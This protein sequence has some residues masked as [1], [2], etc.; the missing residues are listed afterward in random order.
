MQSLKKDSD[1]LG[2]G[3]GKTIRIS[4]L[5][6]IKSRVAQRYSTRRREDF[7]S[8]MI[9]FSYCLAYASVRLL[10]SST[11]ELDEAE[12][13]LN[14]A[15]F[16]L[17]Y[18]DQPPLYS[19]IIKFLSLIF[20][21]NLGTIILVKYALIFSFFFFFYLIARSFWMPKESLI[22]T[23]SLLLFPTYGYEFHRDLSH[24]ILMTMTAVA[25]CLFYV[26]LLQKE[27]K[28]DYFLF[29]LSVGLGFLSKVNFIF[30]LLPLLAASM[31]VREGRRAL[32]DKK[33]F[34]SILPCFLVLLPHIFWLASENFPSFRHAVTES[35][36]GYLKE[37]SVKQIL[38]VIT[39]VFGG[40]LVF[41]FSFILF[42]RH[43]LDFSHVRPPEITLLQR[44]AL[45]GLISPVFLIFFLHSAYFSGR[46]LAP[47]F[48]ILPLALFPLIKIDLIKIRFR[49][50][51][52]FLLLIAVMV[53]AARA[54]IGFL[55][56]TAGKF[57]RI[58][59]PY[60]ALS[61]QIKGELKQMGM[62]DFQGF[63]ILSESR[64]IGVNIMSYLPGSKFVSLE[65]AK[66]T[67]FG[68]KPS[69]DKG[70]IIVWDAKKERTNMQETILHTFPSAIL[71]PPVEAPH[72]H[73]RKKT[74]YVLGIAVIP[75]ED[76]KS[77]AG[78][79]NRQRMD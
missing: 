13:F 26:R 5:P 57:E 14:G 30:F 61:S 67:A 31:T 45:F 33:I 77:A 78:A 42:F 9:I 59:I 23:G 10:V 69:F 50:F 28:I 18:G 41:L 48:F 34:Y 75:Q 6:L 1:I 72:I 16:S 19:W 70:G 62:H 54:F 66:D 51:S 36:A 25:A 68:Y 2:T 4:L 40:P 46:W 76:W 71:I 44:T 29:G 79:S 38:S 58:N 22:I 64:H 37:D 63:Y 20:G 52:Y 11:L 55:P 39:P 47:V 8:A 43:R 56:D 74:P 35:R 60:Q 49:T 12:Q 27:K 21:L 32:F 73:S 65:S 53:I 17:G 24:T 3:R 7:F 15:Y